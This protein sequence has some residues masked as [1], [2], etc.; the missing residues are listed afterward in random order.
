MKDC[1]PGG[2]ATGKKNEGHSIEGTGWGAVN[3]KTC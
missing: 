1:F 2:G 3:E